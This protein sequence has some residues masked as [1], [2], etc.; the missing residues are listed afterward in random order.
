MTVR[1]YL[2]SLVTKAAI[3]TTTGGQ[4][5]AQDAEKFISTVRDQNDVFGTHVDVVSVTGTTKNIDVIGLAS[6]LL[7]GGVEGEAPSGTQS[8][9]IVR[10][11]LVTKEVILPYDI[12]YDFLEENIEGKDVDK[13]IQD[14]FAK[15]FS[16]DLLDLGCNGDEAS[17]DEFVKLNNGWVK[18]LEADED[19]IALSVDAA[20]V[21]KYKD[22]I[23]PG[24][25]KALPPKWRND[26]DALAFYVSPNVEVDYRGS[27]AE[28]GTALGDQFLVE[29]KA[30]RFN[31]I[32]VKPVAYFSDTVFVLTL[33][34]N[35][36]AGISRK[37][38]YETQRQPRKRLIEY[39]ITAKVD[40]NYAVSEAI[41]YADTT[42]A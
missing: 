17:L 37:I 28:R 1:E 8:P 34:K 7:R 36:K 41:A 38:T 11:Q 30:A 10:R 42:P 9:T 18:V 23:F 35:F 25:L 33:K 19:T 15:Q 26:P 13:L 4:L 16:N 27:L 39:T 20:D 40:Y 21:V 29:K 32:E 12:T 5:T 6:R 3:S 31:G 14:A 24:L 2:K 22:I